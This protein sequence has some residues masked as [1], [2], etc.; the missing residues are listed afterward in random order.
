MIR[1]YPRESHNSLHSLSGSNL[2]F[3]SPPKYVTYNLLGGRFNTLVKNSQAQAH[4][5]FYK[6]NIIFSIYGQ[7]YHMSKFNKK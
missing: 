2:L 3:L 5:S 6:N 7:K 4:I 1:K